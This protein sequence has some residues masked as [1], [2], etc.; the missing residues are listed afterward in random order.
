M[1]QLSLLFL[2]LVLLSCRD[3]IEDLTTIDELRFTAEYAV[4]LI[5]SEVSLEELIGDIDDIVSLTVDPDGLLRFRYTGELPPVGSDQIFATLEPLTQGII[6]PITQQ[7]QSVPFP[8][9]DDLRLDE[10]R[11]K[12]GTLRYSLPNTYEQ[13]VRINLSVPTARRGEERLEVSGELPA[14]SGSGTPPTLANPDDPIDLSGYVLDLTDDSLFLEYRISD[15]E[16]NALAPSQQTLVA[17]EN[18]SFSYVEGY[19]GRAIYPGESSRVDIDFFESY[20]GGEVFFADPSIT[21]TLRNSF[22]VP[23][24]A[25]VDRLN[26]ITLEDD[27]LAVTGEAIT[28]GFDFNYPLTPGRTVLTTFVFDRSNSNLP[29]VF[30]ARPVAVDYAISAIIN[31]DGDTSITGFLTDTSAYSAR[32]DV[33]LPLVGSAQDFTVS[34]TFE[35]DLSIDEF[36]DLVDLELRLTTDN[37][38]P[39]DLVLTGI[40]VNAEGQPLT[41]LTDGPAIIVRA[42]PVDSDGNSTGVT[43]TTNDFLYTEEQVDL[44][45]ESSQLVLTSTFATSNQGMDFVRI[46]DEQRLR[47]RLGAILTVETK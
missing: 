37:S 2:L 38:L 34:D 27:T 41:N 47:V 18:L 21:V 31:P 32:V 22:G 28:N 25:V 46:R 11:L 1:K 15:L 12:G 14:Y 9:P 33:E 7:R 30:S 4:P 36:S 6:L 19:L 40:F 17:L 35:V 39:F 5:D 29:E 42:S 26:V 20:Q 44:I 3:E 13:A 23:S 24:R 45:R 8:L 43:S 16:G 10:L